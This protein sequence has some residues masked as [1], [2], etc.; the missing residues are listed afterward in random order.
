VSNSFQEVARAE[1]LALR[2]C[3]GLGRLSCN[4]EERS[5]AV[6][7]GVA[8]CGGIA[9]PS[10]NVEERSVE[11]IGDGCGQAGQRSCDK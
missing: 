3:G 1:D 11:A 2:G 9:E 8:G 10:C 5:K 4:I 7:E 6:S